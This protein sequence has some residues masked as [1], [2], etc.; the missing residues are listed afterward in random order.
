MERE[1]EMH[2]TEKLYRKMTD[3]G[4]LTL[5]PGGHVTVNKSS[6]MPLSIEWIDWYGRKALTIMHYGKMN[7]DLM[8]DPEVVVV[9]NDLT[10]IAEGVYFRNDYAGVEQFVFDYN[11]EGHRTH[12]RK[13]LKDEIEDFLDGWLDNLKDWPIEAAIKEKRASK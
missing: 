7:G 9:V 12:I 5:E 2:K 3:V 10:Q 8:R 6:M 4:L 13:R 11:D 1:L